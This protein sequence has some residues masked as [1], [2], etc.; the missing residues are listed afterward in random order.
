MPNIASAV[1][2]GRYDCGHITRSDDRAVKRALALYLSREAGLPVDTSGEEADVLAVLGLMRAGRPCMEVRN[3]R[4]PGVTAAS[5]PATPATTDAP[6]LTITPEM[7]EVAGLILQGYDYPEIAEM[8]Y[9]RKE[10]VRSHA[11]RITKAANAHSAM[12]GAVK[13]VEWGYVTL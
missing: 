9:R 4:T 12:A 2:C 10:T 6:A 5:T 11:K 1:H 13:M 7:V 3:Y 8:T